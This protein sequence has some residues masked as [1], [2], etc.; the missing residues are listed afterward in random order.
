[1][2][3]GA[4]SLRVLG[5]RGWLPTSALPTSHLYRLGLFGAAFAVP[6][7]VVDSQ[8]HFPEDMNTGWPESLLYYPAMAFLA[9]I[10]FHLAPLALLLT[11]LRWNLDR[12]PNDT[13]RAATAIAVVAAL[14]MLFHTLDVM[15]GSDQ[16]LALFVIPQLTT[17][18]V[19]QL[20]I[21]RRYG[22][23]ATLSFRLGYYLIWHIAW[24][25][26]RLALLF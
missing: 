14:E 5:L 15:T 9:E 2:V 20:A 21:L 11:A 3:V 17:F 19:C 24:G 23:A 13:R 16:R 6:A 22:F 12:H 25:E 7:V 4:T 18:G 1:V 10:V 26:A 8:I